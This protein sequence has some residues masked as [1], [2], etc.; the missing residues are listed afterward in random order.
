VVVLKQSGPWTYGALA[1]HLLS[2]AGDDDRGDVSATFLNPFLAH[3]W[4]SGAGV[5]LT[6]EYTRDWENDVSVMVVHP[7]VT[8]VTKIGGQTVSLAIGPRLHFAPD[9]HA[10][11][12]LRTAVILVFPK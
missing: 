4:K 3:N 6:I 9:N 5:T 10:R 2:V 12:G 11:Y 1:N 8:G 7:L